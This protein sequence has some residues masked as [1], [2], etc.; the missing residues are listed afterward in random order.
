MFSVRIQLWWKISVYIIG[1]EGDI[2]DY[3][4]DLRHHLYLAY[5]LLIHQLLI[6]LMSLSESSISPNVYN[7]RHSI[8][9]IKTKRV[10]ILEFITQIV[11]LDIISLW[12]LEKDNE[13]DLAN[14]VKC[15]TSFGILGLG[16]FTYSFQWNSSY[17]SNAFFCKV[18]K[19][20]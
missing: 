5:V 7:S 16:I 17:F 14:K 6:L 10:I 20:L 1:I 18:K 13:N 15:M 11:E 19:H 4:R 2:K 8:I 3:K 9:D 12:D